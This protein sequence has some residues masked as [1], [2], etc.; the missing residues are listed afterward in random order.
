MQNQTHIL[1]YAQ[2]NVFYNYV[3][4]D[5]SENK[6]R[7][8]YEFSNHLSNIN[9]VTTDRKIAVT[10]TSAPT[11]VQYFTSEIIT[12]NDYFCFGFEMKGRSVNSGANYLYGFNGKRKD[13]EGLGGGGATYDYGFRIYNPSLG[14]FLSVD[15]LT[16]SYPWYT[17]YQFAANRPIMAIDVDGLE[18]ESTI[19]IKSN[20]QTSLKEV[21]YEG[22]IM[23]LVTSS[24]IKAEYVPGN[25]SSE[26]FTP[27]ASEDVTVNVFETN[28]IVD[29]NGAVIGGSI[30]S[31]QILYSAEDSKGKRKETVLS[32]NIVGIKNYDP[33]TGKIT[34]LIGKES[35][36]TQIGQTLVNAV[37]SNNKGPGAD[38]QKV[39]ADEVAT[40]VTSS[41]GGAKDL[42]GEFVKVPKALDAIISKGVSLTAEKTQEEY[43]KYLQKTG[44]VLIDINK[45]ER[46]FS[47]RTQSGLKNTTNNL[48]STTVNK[49]SNDA[50]KTAAKVY[51]VQ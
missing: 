3:S 36:L 6:V 41:F 21:N 50:S 15:P 20:Y 42:V 30:V 14:R 16:D 40:N 9:L 23:T 51:S 19:I 37:I 28:L 22:V 26:I 4:S 24:L 34:P 38:L 8:R 2:N 47:E 17:P 31:K 7:S 48:G 44:V 13:P 1:N 27:P 5:K 25:T 12:A 43:S 18:D 32:E 33:K 39:I 49:P 46:S 10:L 35:T 29:G 11:L 45:T